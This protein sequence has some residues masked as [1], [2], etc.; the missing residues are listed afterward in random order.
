MMNS[1]KGRAYT[2][3]ARKEWFFS[4]VLSLILLII[5][6]FQWYS[7]HVTYSPSTFQLVNE[8]ATVKFLKDKGKD[9]ARGVPTG[10]YLQSLKFVGSSEVHV[11]GYVWQKYRAGIHD[12]VVRGFIFPES[13]QG[14]TQ[15]VVYD[16]K[17]GK[18]QVIGWY[19]ETVLR[20]N[21]N[22]SK[23]PFDHKTVWIRIWHKDFENPQILVPD[24]SSYK[25]TGLTD[26]FGYEHT[27]VLAGWELMETFFDY[28]MPTY[29][30]DFGLGHDTSAGIDTHPDLQFNIVIMRSLFSP[31]LSNMVPLG[32]VCAL[33]FT[34][35]V[36]STRNKDKAESFGFS[37]SAVLATC[38][39]LF[40]LVL[41]SHIAIRGDTSGFTYLEYFF[42]LTYI[43]ILFTAVNSFL[44]SGVGDKDSGFIGY[45][46]NLIPDLL[47]WP[48]FFG[49]SVLLTFFAL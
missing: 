26:A 27:M 21:F 24:Y 39:G 18:E 1:A 22:Y 3:G 4:I 9:A 25:A 16:V 35:L 20:Q 45:K 49:I 41:L 40:F 46:D 32:I 37:A 43:F 15:E 5:L 17:R 28:Y 31:F 7:A 10:I 2:Q 11:T 48:A 42:I 19:F 30:T 14:E 8:E 47:F 6:C 44:I 38:S 33:L 29:D 34:L 23:Y 12:G 13:V 36:T